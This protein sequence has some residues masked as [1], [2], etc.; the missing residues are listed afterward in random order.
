MRTTTAG[1]LLELCARL[2]PPCGSFT[3]RGIALASCLDLGLLLLRPDNI[4]ATS[5]LPLAAKCGF[6]CLIPLF[7]LQVAWVLYWYRECVLKI[8]YHGGVPPK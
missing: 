3:R 6:L 5:T 2:A 8:L 1:R 7:W 4:I